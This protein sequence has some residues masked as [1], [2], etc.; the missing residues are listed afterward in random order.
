MGAL[1]KANHRTAGEARAVFQQLVEPLHGDGLNLGDATEVDE[2]GKQLRS[3]FPGSRETG[4]FDNG[5]FNE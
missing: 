5:Q 3:R 2:L 1:A 4:L